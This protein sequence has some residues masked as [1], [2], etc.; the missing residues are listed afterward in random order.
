V[1]DYQ[2]LFH[3]GVR[4]TDLAQAMAEL[5]PALSVTWAEPRHGEQR[6]WT[7]DGGQQ[8][9]SL[10]F[11]YSIEGPQH[12]ELLQGAPGSIWSAAGAPGVH[13]VGVWVDDLLTETRSLLAA[14]WDLV[15]AHSAPNEGFGM[16]IYLAPP[17]GLL[18]ELVDAAVESH[19]QA[20][21]TASGTTEPV[22]PL[23][24]ELTE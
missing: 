13:H 15:G 7:P 10:S 14:G 11:T 3:T 22:L 5:G 19:F 8:S 18:V 23:T 20:W 6:L 12:V 24:P 17:S 21:W 1:I 4:V 2:R 16:Y 9:V